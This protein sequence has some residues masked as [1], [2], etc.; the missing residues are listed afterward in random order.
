M[1]D[2]VQPSSDE[3]SRRQPSE[4]LRAAFLAS[5]LSGAVGRNGYYLAAAWLL[6]AEGSGSASVAAFLVV[7]SVAEVASSPVAGIMTDHFERR[8]LNALAEF[9]RSIIIFA[10]AGALLQ[11]NALATL[12]VSAALFSV[13][14][15]V[16]LTANQSMIPAAG[17]GRDP[18]TWNS[19]VVLTMQSG[20]LGAALSAGFLLSWHSP[21]APFAVFGACFLLSGGLLLPLRLPSAVRQ[22]GLVATTSCRNRSGFRPLIAVYAMFYVSAL[23]VSVLASNFVFAE[24]KGGAADFGRLEAAWSAGSLLG[25][26]ALIAIQS[27]MRAETCHVLLLGLTALMFM[28]FP[29]LE[30]A[31]TAVLFAS[32]GFLYN[33]GRVSVEVTFQSQVDADCLGRAKG[34]M[35]TVAVLLSLIVFA[36]VA[37]VGD[38]A[39]P[40]TIFLSF[41][42]VLLIAI[43]ALVALG[44]SQQRGKS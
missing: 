19:A 43:F 35:H 20:N 34:V 2:M 27:S 39:F 11:W 21:A 9:A 37:T 30:A 4:W 12:C 40:S 23:L 24:R 5:A 18:V 26:T 7:A 8:R 38:R 33:L 10:T 15:R 1:P 25:A 22:S 3:I 42:G 29:F 36:I 28:L 32:L 14:D 6:A 41:G 13:C 31:W 44:R 17:H 16:A